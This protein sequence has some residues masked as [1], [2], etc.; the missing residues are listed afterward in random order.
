MPS[1]RARLECTSFHRQYTLK[2]RKN[3]QA[4]IMTVERTLTSDVSMTRN[5]ICRHLAWSIVV[6]N[7][8]C[9]Y[10]AAIR[11]EE[12]KLQR[13]RYEFFSV[14]SGTSSYKAS[15]VSLKKTSGSA[16]RTGTA[17]RIYACGMMGNANNPEILVPL[18]TIVILSH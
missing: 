2:E 13:F 6:G 10:A 9:W 5:V 12:E 3:D 1:L 8:R 15:G 17:Y 18:E 14:N 16:Q 7:V 4:R 11:A